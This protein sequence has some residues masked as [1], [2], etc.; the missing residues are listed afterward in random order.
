MIRNWFNYAYYGYDNRKNDDTGKDQVTRSDNTENEEF[1][2][3]PLELSDPVVGQKETPEPAVTTS[4]HIAVQ[5]GNLNHIRQYIA[6]NHNLDE[7]DYNGH[8]A[9]Y[10][11]IWCE[12]VELVE[13]FVRNGAAISPS[14]S[15]NNAK[16]DKIIDSGRLA[17][18]MCGINVSYSHKQV[19]EDLRDLFLDRLKIIVLKKGVEFSSEIKTNL[20]VNYRTKLSKNLLDETIELLTKMESM[21]LEENIPEIVPEVEVTEGFVNNVGMVDVS[22]DDYD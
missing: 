21:I 6:N 18:S 12:K 1:I 11:A 19:N 13:I 8:T 3:S 15:T 16:I 20:E 5:T 2:Q 10:Q 22:L 7:S 14:I 17:D 4:L 9:L